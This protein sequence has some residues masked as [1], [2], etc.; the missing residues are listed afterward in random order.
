MRFLETVMGIPMSIDVRGVG[1]AIDVGEAVERAFQVLRDA[2]SRFSTYRADSELSRINGNGGEL[3]AASADFREVVALGSAMAQ[4]SE[5][6]FRVRLPDGRW[7]LDGV[8]KGWAADRAARELAAAGL[9]N[10]C[11]NAGGDVAV[12][13]SPGQGRPWNVAI[14]SPESAASMLA[15]LAVTQGGVATSGAYERGEHIV[16]GRT[17]AATC[18]LRS[19]TVVADDLLTADLLATAVFALG[20]GGPE[21]ALAHGARGVLAV[22]ADGRLIGAG[23]LVFATPADGR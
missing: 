15:V 23:A 8:V 7:D 5:R 16:D 11:L 6:A 10:F 18:A 1:D 12:A 22:E 21:W 14:R 3:A 4:D 17:G 9:Q 2:D 19:A 13:G 20:A